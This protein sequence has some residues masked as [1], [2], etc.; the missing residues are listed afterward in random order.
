ML[1]LPS[2]QAKL[3][4]AA[5]ALLF[6]AHRLD[7]TLMKAFVLGGGLHQ[8]VLH[9]LHDNLYLRSQVFEVINAIT[10]TEVMR[11]LLLCACVLY[12]C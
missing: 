3:Q 11:V 6:L 8:L 7:W 2:S 9:L 10:A 12:K 5:L 4:V 1:L